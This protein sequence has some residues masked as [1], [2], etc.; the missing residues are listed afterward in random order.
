MQVGKLISVASGW[1]WTA[2]FLVD[3]MLSFK[4]DGGIMDMI[5]TCLFTGKVF[6]K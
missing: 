4:Y 2:D 1:T 3:F 6:E 5:F